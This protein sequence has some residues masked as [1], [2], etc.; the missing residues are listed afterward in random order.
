MNNIQACPHDVRL[1]AVSM[2]IEYHALQSLAKRMGHQGAYYKAVP[3]EMM[4]EVGDKIKMYVGCC[5]CGNHVNHFVNPLA[6]A[7]HESEVDVLLPSP[8]QIHQVDKWC[9][10]KH[11]VIA[12]TAKLIALQL[13]KRCTGKEWNNAEIKDIQ[14][15]LDQMKFEVEPK[16]SVIRA[17]SFREINLFYPQICNPKE[18]N[19]KS[20][21]SVWRKTMWDNRSM[22][23]GKFSK[24]LH[25]KKWQK[26]IDHELSTIRS[27]IN[28]VHLQEITLGFISNDDGRL[29]PNDQ[30]KRRI[31][32]GSWDPVVAIKTGEP[33][34][35]V[36]SLEE[37]E[38]YMM[39]QL[40]IE[41]A[42]MQRM[43]NHIDAQ[44]NQWIDEMEAKRNNTRFRPTIIPTPAPL[45]ARSNI[46]DQRIAP[47]QSDK[48]EMDADLPEDQ[49]DAKISQEDQV[50]QPVHRKTDE[51]KAIMQVLAIKKFKNLKLWI[52]REGASSPFKR[53]KDL[54]VVAYLHSGLQPDG[55]L[56]KRPIVQVDIVER[57]KPKKLV[58]ATLKPEVQWDWYTQ[59]GINGT[60]IRWI[61]E[62]GHHYRPIL[63]FP[64]EDPAFGY[65][66]I[67][68]L[69]ANDEPNVWAHR[70]N[71]RR[72]NKAK[73]RKLEDA[74]TT[75]YHLVL[76]NEKNLSKE[77]MDMWWWL[78][79]LQFR[80]MNNF[81]RLTDENMKMLGKCYGKE[82]KIQAK[83]GS[84]VKVLLSGGFILAATGTPWLLDDAIY[85]RDYFVSRMCRINNLP[86]E[87][88]GSA[89]VD[90]WWTGV[91]FALDTVGS[92]SYAWTT[93]F[94]VLNDPSVERGQP[95]AATRYRIAWWANRVHC[96]YGRYL[97][98][99]WINHISRKRIYEMR[100]HAV[101]LGTDKV[102]S[103]DYVLKKAV[104]LM[105]KFN[106]KY[107]AN[108]FLSS[109]QSYEEHVKRKYNVGGVQ[110]KITPQW[111]TLQIEFPMEMMKD[112]GPHPRGHRV[113]MSKK[114]KWKGNVKTHTLI[115]HAIRHGPHPIVPLIL[116]F[117]AT[118]L[119]CYDFNNLH[120]QLDLSMLK[121]MILYN[122]LPRTHDGAFPAFHNLSL[123]E[124]TVKCRTTMMLWYQW[125]ELFLDATKK[126]LNGTELRKFAREEGF[127]A[128]LPKSNLPDP[129]YKTDT[130]GEESE[131]SSD[132]SEVNPA[133]D[134]NFS[135]GDSPNDQGS[136]D[137]DMS[138]D[139]GH[140][141]GSDDDDENM[142]EVEEESIDAVVV[143]DNEHQDESDKEMEAKETDDLE[144][145]QEM[146]LEEHM[147]HEVDDRKSYD[148]DEQ[149][150]DSPSDQKEIDLTMDDDEESCVIK[151]ERTMSHLTRDLNIKGAMDF[152]QA[153]VWC[154]KLNEL[155]NQWSNNLCIWLHMQDGADK[156]QYYRDYVEPV[157]TDACI[158]AAR[159]FVFSRVR[160]RRYVMSSA[161]PRKLRQFLAEHWDIAIRSRFP[162][163]SNR[164]LPLWD[165]PGGP[166]EVFNRVFRD[167]V[168]SG[169]G[170]N[171]S[172]TNMHRRQR[173][174]RRNQK[175]K[176][177]REKRG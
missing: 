31:S 148:Q 52:E 16:V 109:F 77:K 150:E 70:A 119:N 152:H 9:A 161:D 81:L 142:S 99:A 21:V 82:I 167:I 24:R 72:R 104:K 111:Y 57:E 136:D 151:T 90:E 120:H 177:T 59:V 174:N 130:E 143:D 162:N 43:A 22:S 131:E 38:Q 6:I 63:T 118:R 144:H 67:F 145:Q 7:L 13:M 68:V 36:Y 84:K 87:E 79:F 98:F 133:N 73:R 44:I 14:K 20:R 157:E 2:W 125:L 56:I 134:D 172:N 4:E 76:I 66:L 41:R 164:E 75:T 127:E 171:N 29:P 112:G 103:M 169:G 147:Q 139:N 128:V 101:R 58:A 33:M 27:A 110:W 123:E 3:R 91:S 50:E 64:V 62:K 65:P 114:G 88:S 8:H 48:A 105:R 102:L 166:G 156:D 137:E 60:Y 32:Q 158:A 159:T 96:A 108:D 25:S 42:R 61:P 46:P 135:F 83:P 23:S 117:A 160:L 132:E 85:D 40:G 154:Q 93:P 80:N 12:Q 138:G 153:G 106:L 173:M 1:V 94:D 176:K 17:P 19:P 95:H 175:G 170:S 165:E 113:L 92:A 69:V 18:I 15:V 10:K 30:H 78:I 37:I 45:I 107:R 49:S 47:K 146:Q 122:I 121:T 126:E 140:A 51:E 116:Y 115:C 39:D 100:R 149:H 5:K 53:V 141:N 129:K 89:T 35:A 124:V 71:L 54:A 86:T 26:R 34:R 163:N 168:R 28:D 97:E 74:R 11:G 155:H 55:R